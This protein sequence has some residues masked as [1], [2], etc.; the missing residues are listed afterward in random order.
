[1]QN[2]LLGAFDLHLLIALLVGKVLLTSLCIAWGFYGE[3]L[4][5]LIRRRRYGGAAG[6]ICCCWDSEI[7][8]PCCCNAMAGVAAAVIGAPL[9]LTY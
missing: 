6:K 7:G 5:L 2:M 8:H 4:H 9:T 1:M 3:L